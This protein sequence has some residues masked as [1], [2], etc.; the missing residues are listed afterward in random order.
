MNKTS[1]FIS[2]YDEENPY[3][4]NKYFQTVILWYYMLSRGSNLF[5]AYRIVSDKHLWKELGA[6]CER[7]FVGLDVDIGERTNVSKF[8]FTK[9]LSQNASN[10]HGSSNLII[11]MDEEE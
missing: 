1:K 4:N 3:E 2:I 5:D 11:G 6:E 8:D 7:Y 10:I 9:L